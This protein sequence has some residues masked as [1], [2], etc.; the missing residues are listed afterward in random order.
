MLSRPVEQWK[1]TMP[2]WGISM[3]QMSG[4]MPAHLLNE[5]KENIWKTGY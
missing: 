3:T 1:K 5:R 4:T 2:A